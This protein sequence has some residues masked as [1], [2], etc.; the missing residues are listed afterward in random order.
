V[1]PRAGAFSLVEVLIV[2]LILAILAALVMPR[3]GNLIGMVQSTVDEISSSQVQQ[4]IDLYAVQHGGQY[5]SLANISDQLTMASNAAGQTAPVGT[6]GYPFGPYLRQIPLNAGSRGNVIGNG[7][8]GSSDYR[9]LEDI[10]LILPNHDEAVLG[11]L[12]RKNMASLVEGCVRYAHLFDGQFP[13]SLEHLVNAGI[14]KSRLARLMVNPRTGQ[15]PG[16]LYSAPGQLLQDMAT[17][18]LVKIMIESDSSAGDSQ[19]L[20]GYADGKLVKH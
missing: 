18:E 15:S 5:P 14:A 8:V 2:V 9:Y 17:P 16:F 13:S 1:C 3:F 10:G 12:A 6:P 19:G 20:I 11:E 7:P 4:A